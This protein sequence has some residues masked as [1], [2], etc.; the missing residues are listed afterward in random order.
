[1]LIGMRPASGLGILGGPTV[2]GTRGLGS[3][4]EDIDAISHYM[5]ETP[6]K[7][8]AA[9][10][11]QDEYKLWIDSV[12]WWDKNYDRPT[13]DRARNLRQ[14]FNLANATTAAEQTAVQQLIKTG[15]TTEEMQG[16]PRRLSSE[17]RYSEK[18]A[19]V[20]APELPSWAKWTI[21]AAVGAGAIFALGKV[22]TLTEIFAG[23]HRQHASNPRRRGDKR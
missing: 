19:G 20:G 17:G 14:E 23:K 4:D 15:L 1:M 11:K 12:S 6:A 2:F 21:V 10:K 22:T 16:D 7:T 8:T 13:Y 5:A 18:D 3:Q 9:R